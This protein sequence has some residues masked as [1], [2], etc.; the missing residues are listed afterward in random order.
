M[1]NGPRKNVVE[2][3]QMGFGSQGHINLLFLRR[4]LRILT[5]R[6]MHIKS[7]QSPNVSDSSRLFIPHGGCSKFTSTFP[8]YGHRPKAIVPAPNT[9]FLYFLSQL[10]ILRR[11][12]LHKSELTMIGQI[13]PCLLLTRRK[14]SHPCKCSK[15]HNDPH[16]PSANPTFPS[17]PSFPNLTVLFLSRSLACWTLILRLLAPSS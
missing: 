7:W 4:V 5:S 2:S 1:W 10:L 15:F 16:H 8:L 12:T 9:N 6:C 13:S 14:K 17:L 3:P 11:S